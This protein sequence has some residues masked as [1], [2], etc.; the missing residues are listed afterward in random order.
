[1]KPLLL[2]LLALAL[3]GCGHPEG[4]MFPDAPLDRVPMKQT[5]GV[6]FFVDPDTGCHYLKVGISVLTPR[7]TADGKILCVR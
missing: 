2:S 1:M 3:A 5:T 6:R 4:G 7:L